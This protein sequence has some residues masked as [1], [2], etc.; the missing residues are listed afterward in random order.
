MSNFTIDIE[1]QLSRLGKDIQHFVER[2][3]PVVDENQDF[4]PAC[5]IIEKESEYKILLELP[6]MSKK[7]VEVSLND[8]VLTISGDKNT[9]IDENEVF[10]RRERNSGAFSRSFAL[11][12]T[13]DFN[14]ID[15]SFKNGVLTIKMSK[16]ENKQKGQSI[17]IS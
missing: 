17:P 4:T 13:V 16:T 3:A 2:I 12:D 10:E 7:E 6:G 8:S 5:D 15:A 11:P 9:D 1:D 14:A